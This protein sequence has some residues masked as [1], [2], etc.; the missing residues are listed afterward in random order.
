[1][2]IIQVGPLERVWEAVGEDPHSSGY[3]TIQFSI[4]TTSTTST[5]TASAGGNA[6]VSAT[7]ATDT[8][9]DFGLL[10]SNTKGALNEMK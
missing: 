3:G 1:M 2:Y 6:I 8:G 10:G 4:T 5:D 7:P 9:M